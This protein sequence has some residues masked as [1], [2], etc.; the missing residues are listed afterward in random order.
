MQSQAA[1][2]ATAVRRAI[3]RALNCAKAAGA[4]HSCQGPLS[5]ITTAVSHASKDSAGHS[6]LSNTGAT[7]LHYPDGS[8]LEVHNTG[9]STPTCSVKR[10]KSATKTATPAIAK[11][12]T[13]YPVNPDMSHETR[14][15][16]AAA[17]KTFAAFCDQ[18][19]QSPDQA[20]QNHV[21]EYLT[22]LAANQAS[23]ATIRQHRAAIKSA[24]DRLGRSADN[25]ASPDAQRHTVR[26]IAQ[27]K[28]R[29][30]KQANPLDENALSRIRET[31]TKP[32]NLPSGKKEPQHQAT[33]RGLVDIAIA[34]LMREALLRISEASHLNWQ[35]ITFL[36][37][38]TARILIRHSKTD[39]DAEGKTLY[40]CEETAQDLRNIRLNPSPE[41]PLFDL[42]PDRIA[43]R[44]KEAGLHANLPDLLSGHS[45]RVGMAQDLAAFGIELPALMTAGRWKSPVMPARYIENIAAD[46]GAVAQYHR[47]TPLR[48]KRHQE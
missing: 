2:H 27:S 6:Q 46:R 21:A 40:L 5:H 26:N 8:T 25:P 19:G 16:Y 31:A 33:K 10:R 9:V 34:S 3:K 22:H 15:A 7:A 45:P 14:K 47:R 42:S 17:W 39:Q 12:P 24:M 43:N 1:H 11:P 20:Q 36:S 37:D 18:Q 32:R 35:D 38:G 23:T 41:D 29:R 30:Q 4:N 28:A 48:I 13:A 44:I